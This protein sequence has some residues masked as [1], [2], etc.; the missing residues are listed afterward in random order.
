MNDPYNGRGFGN[1]DKTVYP[2][3]TVSP[4]VP[5]FMSGGVLGKVNEQRYHTTKVWSD[6][7]QRMVTAAEY[8][9]ETEPVEHEFVGKYV[10]DAV[11]SATKA[12]P[13]KRLKDKYDPRSVAK[14]YVL[15]NTIEQIPKVGRALSRGISLM[16]TFDPIEMGDATI[17]GHRQRK[18]AEMDAEY[19]INAIHFK[20]AEVM[21]A[22]RG[23][24]YE[25]NFLMGIHNV[26]RV[27]DGFQ[28]FNP[29]SD[30]SRT[31]GQEL[32]WRPDLDQS[33]EK[34][35]M[36][37]E[38][39]DSKAAVLKQRYEQKKAAMGKAYNYNREETKKRV[40]NIA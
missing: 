9:R 12:G 22:V 38:R 39:D 21:A 36:N 27:T 33:A 34:T 7:Q 40:G 4:Y 32:V 20:R 6:N 5:G 15:E 26:R 28:N 24:K 23:D 19:N 14:R 29:R 16:G 30:E 2:K 1:K 3:D 25:P 17:E 10:E 13:V 35:E 37:M 8:L 11:D 31:P 18:K